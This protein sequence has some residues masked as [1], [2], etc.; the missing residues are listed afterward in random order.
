MTDSIELEIKNEAG[1][2]LNRHEPDFENSSRYRFGCGR[3]FC[4]Q[5]HSPVEPISVDDEGRQ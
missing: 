2:Y 1:R 5:D 4:R 3:T